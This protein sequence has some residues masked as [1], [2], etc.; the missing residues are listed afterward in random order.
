MRHSRYSGGWSRMDD[1]PTV[2]SGKFHWPDRPER[3][4]AVLPDGLPFFLQAGANYILKRAVSLIDPSEN[5]RFDA[6]D[7]FRMFQPF[8]SFL[9]RDC[10]NS[11]GF[12]ASC[13]RCDM[14]V[15]RKLIAE[16]LASDAGPRKLMKYRCYLGLEEVAS[17]VS[18]GG[19]RVMMVSGQFAPSNGISDT[20]ESL[21]CLGHNKLPGNCMSPE[22][23]KSRE[24]YGFHPALWSGAMPTS[25]E[26][27]E[28]ER[29]A[30]Q[31]TSVPP[32]F[33]QTF[34]SE[35]QRVQHIAESY[36]E[37][38]KARTEAMIQVTV[39]K[40]LAKADTPKGALST[41]Q[42]ALVNL[43][44]VLNVYY[45]AFFVGQ[46]E[47]D[48][49]LRLAAWSGQLPS[50]V[51]QTTAHFNWR[52]ANLAS[53]APR[54]SGR[55][56]T[57]PFSV[58]SQNKES[59]LCGFKGG[60]NHFTDAVA[61]VPAMLPS[62]PYGLIV[63]GPHKKSDGI[64]GHEKFLYEVCR[65]FVLRAL[66]LHLASI[67]MR[68]RE[69]WQRTAKLTGHR[70]R[71]SMHNIESQLR[72]TRDCL[73]RV[74]SFTDN[75]YRQAQT[76]LDN[77]FRELIEISYAAESDIKGALDVRSAN[78]ETI[79]LGTIVYAAIEAQA[80]LA[81]DNDIE[82]ET[83]GLE[84]LRE[85]WVNQTLVRFALINLINNGLKYSYPRSEEHRRILRICRSTR[86][87][88]QIAVAVEIEN[89]G[90]GIKA[91]HVERIFEWEVRLAPGI[92]SFRNR[93][94]KG[95][96]LWEVRHIVQG[97]GGRIEVESRHHTGGPVTDDNIDFCL[98]KFT[99]IIPYAVMNIKT[100]PK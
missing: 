12:D 96:G 84:F 75:D 31:L 72:M 6:F 24:K 16:N 51:S 73:A 19:H 44:S 91:E 95:L 79:R 59:L 63:V 15:A 49:V 18:V 60:T 52:K 26:L 93:Y 35:V 61:I 90:L 89:F 10:Q 50:D 13:T 94:G 66:A 88:T 33:E 34:E 98:T 46:D 100:K 32:G 7:K 70:V 4:A 56:L 62:G 54:S 76:D 48:T 77:A 45:L 68:D 64:S 69:D 43:Q 74:P 87:D 21:R 29:L 37:L 25:T 80:Q 83:K 99:V 97:H 2:E 40:N 41:I 36:Y 14:L 39:H 11:S 42:D 5:E 8:C 86:Y 58:D 78:R 71:A 3:L 28:L 47:A 27:E 20:L 22:W 57:D 17:I 67:L 1:L 55:P 92:P 82:I 9:R 53:H 81:E 30:R 23:S 38:T 85:V 65:T